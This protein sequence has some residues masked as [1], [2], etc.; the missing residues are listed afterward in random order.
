MIF[1]NN[2][3]SQSFSLNGITYYKNFL[4]HV[5]GEFTRIVNQYD[6]KF[7]LSGYKKYDQ[8][9]V[10]GVVYG[11]AGELQQALLPILYSRSSLGGGVSGN[12]NQIIYSAGFNLVVQNLTIQPL[13][14]WLI[15]GSTYSNLL[16]QS[17]NIPF[18]SA[19][20]IRIDRIAATVNNNFVRIAGPES[21]GNAVA[22]PLPPNM[23]EVTFFT[24]TDGSISTPTPPII[25]DVFLRKETLGDTV[26][27][28]TTGNAVY[29]NFGRFNY[30]VQNVSNLTNYG[31]SK[32]FLGTQE[33]NQLVIGQE[34]KTTNSSGQP[35][36]YKHNQ[37]GDHF[38]W[39]CPF[40]TDFVQANNTIAVWRF[41]G[42]AMMFE[43]YS[44]SVIQTDDFL[45][46]PFL[47]FAFNT[48][49]TTYPMA[50]AAIS[51]G[52]L[53][54]QSDSI[55]PASLRTG[56]PV[57]IIEAWGIKGNASAANGGYSVGVASQN[58][59]Y[60]GS[61]FFMAVQ[62][63]RITDTLGRFGETN[64]HTISPLAS[65]ATGVYIE[66][67]GASLTFKT[68]DTNLTSTAPSVTLTD[69][70]WL[71]ILIEVESPTSIRCRI[72]KGG[73]NGALIYNYPLSSNLPIAIS[74]GISWPQ[75]RISMNGISRI[76]SADTV[77]QLG[78]I[79]TFAKKPNYLK[80]F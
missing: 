58:P 7:E 33:G 55:T 69:T 14:I 49:Q 19:G 53:T 23:V 60:L 9:N 11:S 80:S 65:P 71:F 43:S 17:I 63:S 70:S 6:T 12:T 34:I 74:G 26:I 76:A 40:Q 29:P 51:S 22:P 10:G 44:S 13:W 35:Q 45:Q 72:R 18:S 64:L 42:T 41:T 48:P 31:M 54:L 61:G 79:I 36:V 62:P 75:L 56:R 50:T 5:A 15:F 4:P 59:L 21:V 16:S 38:P 39:L 3:D 1:I 37:A 24:V 2:I 52:T 27:N 73:V 47:D 68:T 28:L 66:I 77:F 32:A 25:G 20:K 46:Q 78:R 67:D 57:E 30:V 8:Y